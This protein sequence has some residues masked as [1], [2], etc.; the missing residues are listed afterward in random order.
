MT[1]TKYNKTLMVIAVLV[2]AVAITGA[3]IGTFAKYLTS[4]TVSEQAEV[5]KFG[6]NIPNTINLFSD[7]YTNVQANEEGNKII[8]P[9]TTGK[10]D[11]AVSGTSEVAYK[12]SANISVDYSEEWDDY[13]PLEFSLNGEDWF[14]L[15]DFK[16]KLETALNSDTLQPN[17]EY[18]SDQTIH[19]MWPFHT[20]PANDEKDTEI[21]ALAAGDN[22]PNVLVTIDVTAAQID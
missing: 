21:G 3:F 2:L 1:K 15:E 12:V 17:Q 13:M 20:S 5:A 19:W 9:G 18:T 4:N 14:G 10:Y 7:S 8:A 6:L 16:T 11:F 22:V